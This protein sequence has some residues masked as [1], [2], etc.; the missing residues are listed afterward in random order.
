MNHPI[1]T[2][3]PHRPRESRTRKTVI[4]RR[5]V[6]IDAGAGF[7]GASIKSLTLDDGTRYRPTLCLETGA[8]DCECDDFHY[9]HAMHEPTLDTP[10]HHC[11]HLR[12]FLKNER[13]KGTLPPMRPCRM[14]G[15]CE[16]EFRLAHPGQEILFICHNCVCSAWACPA[17]IQQQK[18]ENKE[19]AGR[20]AVEEFLDRFHVP[21]ALCPC[22]MEPESFCPPGAIC[23]HLWLRDALPFAPDGTD[24]ELSGEDEREAWQAN[25][26]FLEAQ[27]EWEQWIELHRAAL[28]AG[29]SYAEVF[30]SETV[31]DE[32]L[33]SAP[34]EGD[35][36]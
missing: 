11:K 21:A 10:Q 13:L 25:I 28:R 7:A 4:R 17:F 30:G 27:R 23:S 5:L 22:C 35:L 29:F 33:P 18:A 31:P 20:M 19:E 3:S 6:P 15:V 14:C 8:V 34:L 16:A 2:R 24:P 12:R 1:P 32:L 26:A 36:T 9:R